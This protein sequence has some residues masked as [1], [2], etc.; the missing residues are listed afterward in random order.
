MKKKSFG[1]VFRTRGPKQFQYLPRY[2]DPDAEEMKQR[3]RM[4]EL[5]IEEERIMR[6]KGVEDPQ[7]MRERM[8]SAWQ[9]DRHEANKT[10][11]NRIIIIALIL[12][13]CTAL[14]LYL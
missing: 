2:Y 11:N 8:T 10:A 3:K 12:A 1:T 7:S 13:A 6:E 4:I 14:F 5:E 9:R